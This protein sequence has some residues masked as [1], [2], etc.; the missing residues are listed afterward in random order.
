MD[1]EETLR[2]RIRQFVRDELLLGDATQVLS[3]AD[4]FIETGTIDS[5]GVLEVV[6]FL[7]NSFGFVVHDREMVPEN[8]DSIDNLVRFIQRK[9]HAA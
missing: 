4:S 5:T 7:E 9:Q 1:S 2:V 6:S 3:D 8:L